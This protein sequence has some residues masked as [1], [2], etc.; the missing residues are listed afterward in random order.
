MQTSRSSK[1]SAA[2][3]IAVAWMARSGDAQV[4][5][6]WPIH[7]PDRPQPPVVIPVAAQGAQPMPPPSD[8]VLLF[9]RRDLNEWRGSNG[10]TARWRVGDGY[11][12]VTPG[13]GAI[14]SARGFGD[15]QLHIE[16]ATPIQVTGGGQDR[17][18]SGIH[19]MGLYEVQILDS[20]Q[21][22][23][24]PDGQAGAIYG[25]YPPLVNASRAPGEW[26]VYDIVFR[27][28]RFDAQGAVTRPARI[29]VLHNG[30]LVQDNVELS[31]PTGHYQRPPYRA[32]AD[33]LPITLQDHGN[34]I[35]FRNIWVRELE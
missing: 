9:G 8:A 2:V 11:F 24:Y 26:Q 18:N 30:I 23:T 6:R 28:P 16:W 15:I 13:T 5:D 19:L 22:S 34:P 29:T 20:W 4:S 3:V 32:H 21:N 14:H 7:S 35:R 12:E 33:R 10:A 27:A 17:G 25:Q 31:G 1:Y